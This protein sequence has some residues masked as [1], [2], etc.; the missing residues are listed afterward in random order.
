M[1]GCWTAFDGATRGLDWAADD[2]EVVVAMGVEVPG[3]QGQAVQIQSFPLAGG[4]RALWRLP[5]TQP[6]MA[7]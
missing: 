3:A 6:C 4:F 5:A 2:S 1:A 7:G